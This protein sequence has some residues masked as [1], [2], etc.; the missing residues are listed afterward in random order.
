M[1]NNMSIDW[2]ANC[3]KSLNER[4]EILLNNEL[5]SDVTFSFPSND[6][7]T[8]IFAHKFL[9]SCGSPVFYTMFHGLLASSSDIIEILDISAE[10]FLELLRYIYT[11]QVNLNE[12]SVNGVMY[13]AHKYEV[14][15]LEMKC[16]E[17]KLEHFEINSM[18]VCSL[19]AENYVF[20]DK[21]TQNCF[22]IIEDEF[23]SI[24]GSDEFMKLPAGAI[25]S[26]MQRNYLAT[27]E[28]HLL[29]QVMS[30]AENACLQNGIEPSIRNKMNKLSNLSFIRFPTMDIN[31]FIDCYSS[32]PGMLTPT[33]VFDIFH[34]ITTK[35]K[36]NSLMFPTGK[37]TFYS[38]FMLSPLTK[39]MLRFKEKYFLAFKVRVDLTLTRF[40]LRDKNC[41][42]KVRENDNVLYRND[43]TDNGT[44]IICTPAVLLN[45]NHE[46]YLETTIMTDSYP[47]LGHIFKVNEREGPFIIDGVGHSHLERIDYEVQQKDC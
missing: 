23:E 43:P 14:C 8:E 35:S 30:W 13:A 20:D 39:Y 17:Y 34:F 12:G 24:C 22:V 2:K 45:V 10:D 7:I 40:H 3:S 18:N 25:L 6:N 21:F 15:E 16:T 38:K 4:Y 37:R 31:E 29:R 47:I 27:S 46:Y 5:L 26:L 32:Y 28:S 41:K 19:L 33:E 42:I 9:L 11:E 36:N 1:S 44:M